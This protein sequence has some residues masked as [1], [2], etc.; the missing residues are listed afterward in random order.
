MYVISYGMIFYV[1]F[2]VYDHVH[3][4]VVDTLISSKN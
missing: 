3:A 1:Y 2:I 4:F